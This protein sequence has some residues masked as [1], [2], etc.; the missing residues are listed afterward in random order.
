[1]AELI[2]Y[3]LLG[4]LYAAALVL[5]L[6]VVPLIAVGRALGLTGQLLWHHVRILVGVV[7]RRT[8][9]YQVRSLPPYR[10]EEEPEPA[11]RQ[12]FHGPATRDLRTA[13]LLTLGRFRWTVSQA[14]SRT[15]VQYFTQPRTHRMAAVPFGLT[16]YLGLVLGAGTSALLLAL[17]VLLHT[18]LVYLAQGVV[19]MTAD[20]LRAVDR[21][22]LRAKGLH[23]GMVC[24]QC[25]ELVEYPQY[26]CPGDGCRRRHQDIR[27]GRYGVLRRRCACGRKLPTLIMTGSHR[28]QG[29]CPYC[30]GLLSDSTGLVAETVLPIVGGTAAG[31][32]QLMA[33]MLMTLFDAAARGG[34]P[35]GFADRNTADN[36]EVLREVLSIRGNTLGTQR[37]LPRAH[38]LLLGRRR[39]RRLVH[40]FD[41]AGER[42]TKVEDTDALR[43]ARTARTFVFVLDPLSVTAFWQGLSS[44]RQALVDRALASPVDPQLVFNQSTQTTKRMNGALSRSRLAV[45]VSKYDVLRRHSLLGDHQAEDSAS[46]RA[47]LVDVLGLGNLVRAMEMEYRE[48][49][50]FFTAAVIAEDERVDAGIA[51]LV[52][53]CLGADR[54]GSSASPAAFPRGE[55]AGAR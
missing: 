48:V 28:L 26:E 2:M 37:A 25:Y 17:L 53:W 35:A 22:V 13:C 18:F 40:I 39:A 54:Y 19:R 44:G 38:S 14:F 6:A 31:K 34:P 9:E 41:T 12:Y 55:A 8:P 52:D 16:L 51:S 10:P 29:I 7:H 47:W 33:A 1:M 3:T 4:I 49:R 11:H 43:Y 15:T 24:P 27:P 5:Y 23:H 45:A 20:T 36:Y 30:E 21:A 42:Y 50:F 32:T 46:V